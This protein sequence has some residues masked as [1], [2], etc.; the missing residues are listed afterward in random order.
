MPSLCKAFISQELKGDAP[1]TWEM[2]R[3]TPLAAEQQVSVM[4]ATHVTLKPATFNHPHSLKDLVPLVTIV[5][6]HYLG[7]TQ[8]IFVP[9]CRNSCFISSS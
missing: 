6:M 8:G 1:G 4:N 5:P 7:G 2:I 9:V 3:D